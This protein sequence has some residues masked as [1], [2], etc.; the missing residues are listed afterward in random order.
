MLAEML[1]SISGYLLA[2][3]DTRTKQAS[4]DPEQVLAALVGFHVDFALSHPSLIVVHERSLAILGDPDRKRV[5]ALQRRYVEVWVHAIR[6]ALG[7]VD[8]KRARS[9]AH[10][11]FGLL[12]STPHNRHLPD[13]E[14][15]DLLGELALGALR[16]VAGSGNEH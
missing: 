10:A 3:A 1:R 13:T 9:T 15:A 11:V 4:G 14:L 5:R 12:N 2:G 6:D 7:D 8:E 16:A